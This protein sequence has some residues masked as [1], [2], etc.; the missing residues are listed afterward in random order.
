MVD[1]LVAVGHVVHK[2]APEKIARDDRLCLV[3]VRFDDVVEA[4][5]RGA[6]WAVVRPVV[7]ACYVDFVGCADRSDALG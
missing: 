2:Q 3:L 6:A 5:Q 7:F 1:I 4:L